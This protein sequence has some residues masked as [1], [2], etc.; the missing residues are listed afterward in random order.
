ML[1]SGLAELGWSHLE[2]SRKQHWDLNSQWSL[3]WN[4]EQLLLF[5]WSW[6]TKQRFC[7][8]WQNREVLKWRRLILDMIELQL[9]TLWEANTFEDTEGSLCLL[10]GNSWVTFCHAHSKHKF[11]IYSGTMR[12]F[13]SQVFMDRPWYPNKTRQYLLIACIFHE[14]EMMLCQ[15]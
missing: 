14:K 9:C 5:L 10:K 7:Q 2:Y 15:C 1:L 6:S 3:C 4:R 8:M 13:F 11:Q 12:I